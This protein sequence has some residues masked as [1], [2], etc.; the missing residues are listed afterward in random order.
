MSESVCAV[1]VT[2]NR[3]ELLRKCLSALL[4]QSMQLEEII[5]VDNASSDGTPEMLSKEF[6]EVTH[7]R[8]NSNT[9]GAGGFHEG[10]KA[11][12]EKGYDWIWIMDDDVYPHP[13]TLSN[14]LRKGK[15][16]MAKEGSH[17]I[18]IPCRLWEDGSIA[19]L[20][21]LKYD[22]STLLR[23]PEQV[24]TPL[25]AIYDRLS[26]LPEQKEVLDFAFEGPLIPR[27]AV[28]V[29]GFPSKEYFIYGDD[30]DYAFRLR[31]TGFRLI[32]VSSGRLFR[33]IRPNSK[34]K[35]PPWKLRY[36]IRNMLWLSR[37]YGENWSTRHL[38]PLLWGIRYIIPA[39]LKGRMF[40]DREAFVAIIQ[41]VKEGI[42]FN[43]PQR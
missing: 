27:E 24:R 21:A 25:N 5:V 36:S 30:T 2:Y 14:L 20:S 28:A 26:T 33:M 43:P 34:M 7:I 38:R 16:L 4:S 42:F 6:P 35:T 10:V 37:L 15:E 29:V 12:Y 32:F 3:K 41:G 9:G 17:F 13:E 22:L 31:R 8:L 19:E 39:L 1:V 18:L 11:A 40:N 23:L